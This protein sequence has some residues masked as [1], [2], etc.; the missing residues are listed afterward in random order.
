MF[1]A[2]QER[3]EPSDARE[4]SWRRWHLSSEQ[5]HCFHSPL[6]DHASVEGRS[7]LLPH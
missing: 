5:R 2:V 3:E 6:E 4:P 7:L 1:M